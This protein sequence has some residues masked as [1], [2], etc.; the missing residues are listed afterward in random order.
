[1]SVAKDDVDKARLAEIIAARQE[2]EAW[3]IVVKHVGS[4]DDPL[5]WDRIN[6]AFIAAKEAARDE[7]RKFLKTKDDPIAYVLGD[8]AHTWEK[9]PTFGTAVEVLAQRSPEWTTAASEFVKACI[10]HG[11][12]GGEETYERLWGVSGGNA[13]VLVEAQ[14]HVTAWNS[15]GGDLGE[16]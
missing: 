16:G 11:C 7:A 2:C 9:K 3:H 15:I 10:V 14:R 4:K 6:H 1:M 8:D 13:N 5:M 12:E